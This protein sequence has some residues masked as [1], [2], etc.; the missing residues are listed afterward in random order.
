VLT[1]DDGEEVVEEARREEAKRF[2]PGRRIEFSPDAL[3]ALLHY[4]SLI[5]GNL[6]N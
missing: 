5:Y 4:Y 6:S 1:F 3:T 2:I